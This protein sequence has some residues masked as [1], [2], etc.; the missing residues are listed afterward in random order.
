MKTDLTE[1]E[2][3]V[4]AELING[5]ESTDCTNI[6]NAWHHLSDKLSRK[7]FAGVLGRLAVKGYYK[8]EGDDVWGYILKR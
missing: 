5:E 3:M 8:P 1:N 6:D 2:A 4:L 7:S